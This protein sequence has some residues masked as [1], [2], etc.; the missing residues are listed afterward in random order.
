MCGRIR[1]VST[2]AVSK[3]LTF[4]GDGAPNTT[5]SGG[6]IVRLFDGGTH[7][8]TV[9]DLTLENGRTAANDIGGAIKAADVTADRTRS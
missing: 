7:A 5:I 6:G 1:A 4:E 3:D 8:I 9:R 2:V